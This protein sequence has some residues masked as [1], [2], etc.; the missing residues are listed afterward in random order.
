MHTKCIKYERARRENKRSKREKSA[1]SQSGTDKL[2]NERTKRKTEQNISVCAL[3]PCT[4]SRHKSRSI[5][6][7]SA[8]QRENQQIKTERNHLAGAHSAYRKH[9]TLRSV[10]QL[11]QQQQQQRLSFAIEFSMVSWWLGAHIMVHVDDGQSYN[12]GSFSLCLFFT[13]HRIHWRLLVVRFSLSS[14]YRLVCCPFLNNPNWK[15]YCPLNSSFS[16]LDLYYVNWCAQFTSTHR[17]FY[18]YC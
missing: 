17:T 7:S 9:Y 3:A 15:M 16:R 12:I 4:L 1:K 8:E 10:C 2:W 5:D 18:G 13:V 14:R 6:D 11:K